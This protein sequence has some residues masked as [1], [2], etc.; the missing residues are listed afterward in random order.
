MC[1]LRPGLLSLLSCSLC[2]LQVSRATDNQQC[3]SDYI[4]GRDDFVLDTDDSVADGATFLGS[5]NVSR[6]RDCVR[7]CCRTAG[8]N[9][10]LLEDQFQKSQHDPLLRQVSGCFLFN[11]LYNQVY[12]C[13]F[14]RREGFS[15]FILN[16]V[17]EAYIKPRKPG[18]GDKLP[19]ANAGRDRIVQPNEQVILSGLASRDDFRIVSFDWNLLAGDPSVKLEKTE[20]QDEQLVS[21]LKVGQYVFQLTVT[22]TAGQKTTDDM[23]ITVLSPEQ[24][25]EYCKADKKV[26]PCRGSFPR[27]HYEANKGSC[28]P[29][30]YGGCKG[31]K[32][33]FVG[34]TECKQACSGVKADKKSSGRSGLPQCTGNCHEN[35][36]KCNDD[37]CI[38]SNLECDET[39][40]CKDKS[41]EASCK[42]IRERFNKLLDIDIPK[43]KARCVYPPIT[44]RCRADFSRFYYN[45]YTSSCERFTYGGCDG[46]EN[47]FETVEECVA[48]CRGVT[49]KDVFSRGLFERQK[50]EKSS[51]TGVAIAVVLA[52]CIAVVLALVVYYLLKMKKQNHRQAS[53]PSSTDSTDEAKKLVALNSKPV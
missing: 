34:E 9:V 52:I 30:T 10:V 11:C 31:N 2:L 51:N 42:H 18:A 50:E 53:L 21:N 35:Q 48:A 4:L 8:C 24:S 12:V 6:A 41:D 46:N 19:R 16:T 20:H 5:P 45:P 32:N 29:F 36:F 39:P 25:E 7:M 44:G 28:E 17:H 3:L 14:F 13:K 43:E 23:S 33:N 27:W 38:D 47:R 15:N 40:H 37:C 1:S 22:D 49:G 26:G